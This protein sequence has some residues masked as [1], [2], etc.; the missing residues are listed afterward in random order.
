MCE[1]SPSLREQLNR[2]GAYL[3]IFVASLCLFATLLFLTYYLQRTLNYSPIATGFA[4]LPISVCLA[5]AA[6]LST[7]VLMPRVGPRPVMIVGLLISVLQAVTQIQE[8]TLNLVPKIV[9][10]TLTMLVV[11]PWAIQRLME[12]S[13]TLFHDIPSTF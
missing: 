10:M 3:S 7:I 11:L 6:N 12:Y 9:L 13:T 4:F 2:S 8:Q 1:R 5:V